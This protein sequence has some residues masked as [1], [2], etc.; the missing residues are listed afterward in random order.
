MKLLKGPALSGCSLAIL[1]II[2]FGIG[3]TVCAQVPGPPPPRVYQTG[4]AGYVL[5]APDEKPLVIPKKRFAEI[6][7]EWIVPNALPTINCKNRNLL[8]VD[9]SSIW[10]GLDGWSATFTEPNGRPNTDVLQAGTE[11]QV[12]CE[13]GGNKSYNQTYFWILWAGTS[14][15]PVTPEHTLLNVNR[16]DLVDVRIVADTTGFFAWRRATVYFT[17]LTSGVSTTTTFDSGCILCAPPPGR[18][19][20]P[21][22][23]EDATLF[24]NTAE[25]VVEISFN[26]FNNSKTPNTLNNFGKVQLTK[27]S[28]TDDKGNVYTPGNFRDARQEIDWM[29]TT[30]QSMDDGGTLLACAGISGVDSEI[31]S[32]APY[33]V[34]TPGQPS[35]LPWAP[36]NCNGTP[37]PPP[38]VS[39]SDKADLQ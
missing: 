22:V 29:T 9:G 4:W 32:R 13:P 37:Q 2:C 38:P 27:M 8:Q 28:V 33:Q 18:N 19:P 3:T 23:E 39:S 7:A 11:T 36:G 25:W 26:D 20:G 31:L 1:G 6:E 10:I 15:I 24:G 21:L 30:G 34:V 12:P 35:E 14:Y 5:Y 16:G 17:D